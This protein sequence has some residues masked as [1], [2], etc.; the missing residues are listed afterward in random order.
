MYKETLNS[1]SAWEREAIRN[2]LTTHVTRLGLDTSTNALSVDGVLQIIDEIDYQ[3]QRSLVRTIVDILGYTMDEIRS[4]DRHNA[5]VFARHFLSRYLH[6]NGWTLSSIGRSIN[7]HHTTIINSLRTMDSMLS[8]DR[9]IKEEYDEFV[10]KVNRRRLCIVE[11]NER[12]E[13][14]RQ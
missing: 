12:A 6:D 11:E 14:V 5:V 8:Y 2:A 10:R 13:L 7:R 4:D 3:N 1:R 9:R